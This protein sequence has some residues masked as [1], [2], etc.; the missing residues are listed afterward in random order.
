MPQHV[1][2]F[3][4]NVRLCAQYARL[5]PALNTASRRIAHA[6]HISIQIMICVLPFTVVT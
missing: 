6:P 3:V 4:A 5:A 1:S 2:I